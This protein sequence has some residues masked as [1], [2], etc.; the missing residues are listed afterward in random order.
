MQIAYYM[1][2]RNVFLIG[3]DHNFK[4]DGKPYEKQ[5]LQ[6]EDINHFDPNYFGNQEWQLPNLAASE[7][8]YH[9]AKY[10]YNIDDRGIYDAT[11]NGKLNVFPKITFEEALKR[12]KQKL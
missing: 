1:G 6:G 5:F 10:F 9:L 11:V 12:C 3:V 4:T 2:F 7:L 8:A